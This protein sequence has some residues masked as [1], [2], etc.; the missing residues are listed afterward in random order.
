MCIQ[1]QVITKSRNL[2]YDFWMGT[3]DGE[4]GRVLVVTSNRS[5]RRHVT[6]ALTSAGYH[7][8][9]CSPDEETAST[10]LLAKYHI[11]I[12]D[13]EE[14]PEFVQWALAKLRHNEE[15]VSLVLSQETPNDF[16]YD[17]L[18]QIDLNN[19]IAR[20]GGIAA[21]SSLIDET[22]LIVTCNK[23]KRRDVFGLDKYLSQW[24]IRFHQHRIDGTPAKRQATDS[25]QNFLKSIDCHRSIIAEICT[26]ADELLMNAIFNA[27]RHNDGSA[28]YGDL[29][30]RSDIELADNETIDFCY[31]CDGR[32]VGFSVADPCG[33]LRRE[34]LV[35]YLSQCFQH[36]GQ[37]TIE[38]R[39]AGRGAGLGL[40]MVFNSVT[41]LTFNIQKNV[42]TEVIALFYV[43]SGGRSL[44]TSGRSLNIFFVD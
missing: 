28:K 38:S 6:R 12:V 17:C 13:A 31:A 29:E 40:F 21:T 27:P 24:G 14:R 30:R 16:V 36:A 39:D 5:V 1:V 32:S 22:E 19:L 20:H 26:A 42:R 9:P 25:F 43:R 3:A 23:L 11:V 2:V 7:V 37:A 34:V 15:A 44:R 4:E 35:K 33:T 41:Q 8:D 10:A 18:T